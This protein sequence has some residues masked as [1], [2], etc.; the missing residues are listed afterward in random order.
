MFAALWDRDVGS[1]RDVGAE[2]GCTALLDPE[3]G[4]T[5]LS[6]LAYFAIIA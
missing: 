5:E 3:G 6:L 4:A 2:G 1:E